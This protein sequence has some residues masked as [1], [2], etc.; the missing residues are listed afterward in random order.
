MSLGY[1]TGPG[2]AEGLLGGLQVRSQRLPLPER[3]QMKQHR[4]KRSG[5]GGTSLS[6]DLPLTDDALR[7]LDDND[8]VRGYCAGGESAERCVTIL[9]ERHQGKY[10]ALAYRIVGNYHA[11]EDVVQDSWRTLLSAARH[12]RYEA[13]FTTWFYRVVWNN[14]ASF[15]RKKKDEQSLIDYG[16]LPDDSCEDPLVTLRQ[17]DI[18]EVCARE[19][20]RLS[21]EHRAVIEMRMAGCNYL[22]IAAALNIPVGTVRSRLNR[23]RCAL[24]ARLRKIMD[25]PFGAPKRRPRKHIE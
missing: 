1:K 9:V 13:Q 19:I 11:A 16:H 22:A 14:A 2:A 3:K 23:A 20:A 5:W 4:P 12:I 25:A 7:E 10:H 18:E 24:G 17:K 6:A 8:L 15:L 21:E